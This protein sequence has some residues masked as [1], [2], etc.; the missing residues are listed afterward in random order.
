LDG[1]AAPILPQET[2]MIGDSDVDILTAR[3]CGVRSIGCTFGLSP[4]SLA[5]AG[6][7]ALANAPADWPETLRALTGAGVAR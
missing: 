4:H 2:V 5:A 6:P 3:N 7:D 1:D